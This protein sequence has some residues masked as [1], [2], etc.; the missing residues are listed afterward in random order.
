MKSHGLLGLGRDNITLYA[1]MPSCKACWGRRVGKFSR[2]KLEFGPE[3]GQDRGHGKARPEG[4]C[5][6][7][8]GPQ[9]W[10][11]KVLGTGQLEN[12]RIGILRGFN[13]L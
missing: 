11:H 10:P 2:S 1:Y 7:Q 8:T 5:K 6:L 9:I 4:A 13:E 3:K 12:L